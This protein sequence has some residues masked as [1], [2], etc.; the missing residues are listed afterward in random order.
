MTLKFWHGKVSGFLFV[1]P[2]VSSVE[3][4]L[5]GGQITVGSQQ[6]H[7]D[8]AQLMVE[9][10]CRAYPRP[11]NALFPYDSLGFWIPVRRRTR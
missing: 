9:G 6:S 10:E 7:L 8:A 5:D 3:L 1:K 11:A 2:S 4:G